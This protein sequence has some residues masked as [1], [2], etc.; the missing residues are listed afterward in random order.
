MLR[1]PRPGSLRK[2]GPGIEGLRAVLALRSEFD[3]PRKRLTD[4]MENDYPQYWKAP[5]R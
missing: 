1:S 5:A 4:S 2:G 3:E